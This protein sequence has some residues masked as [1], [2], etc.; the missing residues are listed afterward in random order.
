M[1]PDEIRS[2]LHREPFELLPVQVGWH[3]RD[4]RHR[5]IPIGKR[6]IQTRRRLVTD[7]KLA[8][9]HL[10]G[11]EGILP[12][13]DP[14][15][16]SLDIF[17]ILRVLDGCQPDGL[18]EVLPAGL[19][20][21]LV[22][23]GDRVRLSRAHILAADFDGRIGGHDLV[24]RWEGF[25]YTAEVDRH[26]LD[27]VAERIERPDRASVR[28]ADRHHRRAIPPAAQHLQVILF[29]RRQVPPLEQRIHRVN[30]FVELFVR[31]DRPE[32]ELADQCKIALWGF[33]GPICGGHQH[34]PFHLPASY[35]S[36]VITCRTYTLPR[37]K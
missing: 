1:N 2:L 37:L 17:R 13:P 4:A 5:S 21:R 6:R 25:H 10:C 22:H 14:G 28:R 7:H 8:A 19:D 24:G 23:I 29:L 34:S 27:P 12:R 36:W 35:C 30:S 15:D 26:L 31:T 3:R 16:E 32:W 20:H 18:Q 11:L 9:A 33:S